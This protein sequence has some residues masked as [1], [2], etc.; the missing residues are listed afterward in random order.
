MYPV[1]AIVGRPNVGKSTLF[2]RM[3]GERKAITAKEAGTTRDRVYG[4][5]DAEIP[6]MLV[7]T[8]GIELNKEGLLEGK[9]V[10]QAQTAIAEAD[11]ILFL[12]DSREPLIADDYDAA[13]IIR[14]S[15]SN[16]VLVASKCDSGSSEPSE[17]LELG[18]GMP[19]EV[20]SVHN[21]GIAEMEEELQKHFKKLGFKKEKEPEHDD[22]H[23][24]IA[25]VGRPNVG[26]SS[27]INAFFNEEKVIVSDIPGT[28]RDTT[29]TELIYEDQ[30]YLLMD[31]AGIRKRGAREVGIEKFSVARSLQ[32]LDRADVAVL[33]LDAS[34]GITRQ[35]LHVV[36]YVL[37]SGTGLI[38]AVNK[39]DLMEKGEEP[40]D[41][42]RATLHRKFAFTPW[43]SV[44]FISAKT[45][46]NVH[47]ILDIAVDINKERAKRI[48]TRQL[49]IFYEKLMFGRPPGGSKT[50]RAKAFY[51]TQVDVHP[52][53]FIL[54]VN[55]EEWFHFSYHRF[56]ENRLR[57]EYGFVGTPVRIEMKS[58]S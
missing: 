19:L 2:N 16:V 56:L 49:N 43:A 31:T 52:P 48:P 57:E 29:D 47:K 36:D 37:K 46:K 8:G 22:E 7:D 39:C 53:H 30:K 27:L 41:A 17:F 11:V 50:G 26:K 32:A 9:M 28:T 38:I 21:M 10:Q 54:F 55:N 45:T 13:D 58:K 5:V 35:D 23:V 4:K 24:S 51:I 1:V 20:S 40:Q 12:L 34:E 18:F 6:Y 25:F 44:V 3:I 14:K 33:L 42:W 15:G